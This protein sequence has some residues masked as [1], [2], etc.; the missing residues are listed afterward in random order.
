MDV[1]YFSFLF[2]IMFGLGAQSGGVVTFE[3]EKSGLVTDSNTQAPII[4]GV[5]SRVV[6]AK[7]TVLSKGVRSKIEKDNCSMFGNNLKGWSDKTF[8][9][10]SLGKRLVRGFFGHTRFATSSKASMDGTR[11]CLSS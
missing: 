3:P 4:R 6:N 2:S 7:R 1:H 9:P 5:R 11:E 10:N 8:N